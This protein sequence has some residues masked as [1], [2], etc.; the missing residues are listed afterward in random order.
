MPG[1]MP[2][3]AL[4]S[5][6]QIAKTGIKYGFQ[7]TVDQDGVS[8]KQDMIHDCLQQGGRNEGL[9]WG[10]KKGNTRKGRKERNSR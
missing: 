6:I 5:W 1:M 9:W 10:E 3:S 2:T 4:L 7:I 8:R